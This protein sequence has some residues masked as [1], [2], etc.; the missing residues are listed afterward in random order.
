[1]ASGL[2][3]VPGGAGARRFLASSKVGISFL[4][5]HGAG[6]TACGDCPHG[7]ARSTVRKTARG[8]EASA[9]EP[10]EV[11]GPG[12]RPQASVTGGDLLDQ[13]GRTAYAVT[14]ADR[15]CL[16]AQPVP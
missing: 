9:L 8:S 6:R 5:P 7:Q 14:A 11:P 2:S 12:P 10:V 13:V 4:P 1:M 16:A 3:R 15:L